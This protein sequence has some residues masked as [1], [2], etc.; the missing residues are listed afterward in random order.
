MTYDRIWSFHTKNYSVI[1]DVAPDYDVDLSF[2]ETGETA[3]KL[4]DG[5][6]SAFIARVRVLHRPTG[7]E[8]GVDYL[9]SCIYESPKDFIDHRGRN[10]G[11]YGSYFS[12]MVHGAISEA[13]VS[14]AQFREIK[15]KAA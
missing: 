13:R 15:L 8:L 1:F 12:D 7:A 14:A 11:G 6:Y 2:D 10:A 3:E 4:N 9:G 5:T